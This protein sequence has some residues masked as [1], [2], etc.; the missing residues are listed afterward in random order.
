MPESIAALISAADRG[1][2]AAAGTLFTALY[3]ELHRIARKQLARQ[4]WGVSIGATSL[5]HEAYLDLSEHDRDRF[6][7]E[8]RFLAYA[9]RV[10]R[11]L[12]IDYARNRQAQKRLRWPTAPSSWSSRIRSADRRSPRPCGV[13]PRSP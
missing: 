11:G 9:A 5:L 8:Q 2:P 1:E 10:M 7:D 4:G 12:I 6:P 13:E 3:S